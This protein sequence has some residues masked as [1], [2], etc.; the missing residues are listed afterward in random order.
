VVNHVLLLGYFGKD[1]EKMHKGAYTTFENEPAFFCKNPI[2]KFKSI[3][4]FRVRTRS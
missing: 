2:S 3:A 4:K 1:I